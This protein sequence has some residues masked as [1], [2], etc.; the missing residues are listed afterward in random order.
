M[1]VSMSDDVCNTPTETH[2]AS[3]NNAY[4]GIA[5]AIPIGEFSPTNLAVHVCAEE[6]DGYILPPVGVVWPSPNDEHGMTVVF[7]AFPDNTPTK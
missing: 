5:A 2:I 7:D 1:C 3:R 4:G 6:M